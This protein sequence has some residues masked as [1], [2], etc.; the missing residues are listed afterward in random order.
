M[1]ALHCS[2]AA[3]APLEKR[4]RSRGTGH[5][6]SDAQASSRGARGDPDGGTAVAAPP[7]PSAGRPAPLLV[8]PDRPA[9]HEARLEDACYA[10][11]DQPEH[12]P[13][14]GDQDIGYYLKIYCNIKLF[15]KGHID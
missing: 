12:G 14:S 2:P 7:A 11:L 8:L 15:H 5:P 13:W 1:S 9:G 6:G 3:A 4:G 10:P